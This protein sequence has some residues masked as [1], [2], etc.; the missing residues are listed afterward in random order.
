MEK[1][2]CHSDRRPCTRRLPRQQE[3]KRELNLIF[4]TAKLYNPHSNHDN[5][6]GTFW[7]VVA[8]RLYFVS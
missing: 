7:V 1:D 4:W 3:Q 5:V 6:L 2:F 8:L